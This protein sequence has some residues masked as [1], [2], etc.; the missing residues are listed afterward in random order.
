MADQSSWTWNAPIQHCGAP[1]VSS[2]CFGC[3]TSGGK[4]TL[5][6]TQQT[7]S[8]RGRSTC[9]E[10]PMCTRS[11]SRKASCEEWLPAN[12]PSDASG[13]TG[14]RRTES[15]CARRRTCLA[16]AQVS[17]TSTSTLAST[18]LLNVVCD[19]LDHQHATAKTKQEQHKAKVDRHDHNRRIHELRACLENAELM[20]R[21]HPD[22]LCL[23]QVINSALSL[24][25][26]NF[27]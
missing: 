7:G 17:I 18:E 1:N 6:G 20:A 2:S 23:I 22:C 21:S 24:F 15:A 16:N 9:S 14:W 8:T 4:A 10:S 3:G 5:T 25:S 13:T 11:F 27:V 12:A 26:S 19:A